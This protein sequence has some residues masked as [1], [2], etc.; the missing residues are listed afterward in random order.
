MKK[1]YKIFSLI[2][3]SLVMSF[4]FTIKSYA[5]NA[6]ITVKTGQ[7]T[8][9]VGGTFT[10][11]VTV[12]SSS[13][14]GA[15]EYN[16]NY[17]SS[18]LTLVSNNAAPHIADYSSGSGKTSASY[19]Y[20]FKAK[21]AGSASISISSYSAVD[22]N[23][24]A[25]SVNA[26]SAS[27]KILTQA[28]I[29]A[30]YSKNNYLKSLSVE[31]AELSPAFNKDT[32][33]YDVELEPETK[34]IKVSATKEDSTASIS[35]VGDI[36]VSEGDNKINVTVTA[37][38]GSVRTYVIN[39]KVKELS[40]IEVKIGKDSFTVVRKKDALTMPE[41]Y[42]ESTVKI[43][44]E[45]VP[46]FTSEITKLTLVGLKDDKGNIKLYVYDEKKNNY[47]PYLQIIGSKVILYQTT[48]DKKI[49]I[50]LNYKKYTIRI[51]GNDFECYKLAKN[52]KFA[53]IYGMNVETGKKNW[54]IYNTTEKT[55]QLYNDEEV[56]LLKE[57]INS[58]SI[59][60]LALGSL[61]GLLAIILLI[62]CIV[63]L[64]KKKKLKRK[65]Q[66]ID[67]KDLKS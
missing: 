61:S 32:L 58:Y 50:P 3:V 63:N 10:T 43:G 45:E 40:P 66:K 59:L 62:V 57:K 21:A 64:S 51:D 41:F 23:E 14:L 6:S 34:S 5:A 9:A 42:T 54:Y 55:L 18:K 37:Q 44:E 8:V 22:W 67:I 24:K 13:G 25:L 65:K 19:T 17:D 46:A 30:S 56:K 27:V 20:T 53:L 28:E 4:I 36:E 2:I 60:I 7:S 29:E 1:G 26:G 52:S 35:G 12:Y 31:G 47:T 48:L 11:T 49:D 38:N 15:W 39:A 16:L 33:E